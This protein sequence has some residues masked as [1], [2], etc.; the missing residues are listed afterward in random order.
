MINDITS[1]F[2][3]KTYSNENENNKVENVE[4]D[5][6]SSP[7][8]ISSMKNIIDSLVGNNEKQHNNLVEQRKIIDNVSAE[9]K[10]LRETVE[11][12]TKEIQSLKESISSVSVNPQSGD[13]DLAIQLNML[14][15]KMDSYEQ[16]KLQK[17]LI[18]LVELIRDY[19]VNEKY[20]NSVFEEV[21]SQFGV[22]LRVHPNKN[23][24]EHYLIQ[25]GFT[26]NN[27]SET[28]N[29]FSS[30][31][32]GGYSTNNTQQN[33]NYN[34]EFIAKVNNELEKLEK[35]K[36]EKQAKSKKHNL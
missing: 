19:G 28:N 11:T 6:I 24:L 10:S 25:K 22:D 8:S 31:P 9:N 7:Y 26:L 17:Q 12:L 1:Q 3:P 30:F 15:E 20:V 23:L 35:Y 27:E 16:E 34:Q 36:L 29:S 2:T 33:E 4:Q 13:N 5:N 21:H 18:P 14:K 32:Q